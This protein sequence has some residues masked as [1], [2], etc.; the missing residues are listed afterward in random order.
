MKQQVIAVVGSSS[1]SAGEWCALVATSGAVPA[2]KELGTSAVIGA[3]AWVVAL[4]Q[5]QAPMTHG[6]WLRSLPAPIVLITP[7]TLAAQALAPLVPQLKVISPPARAL[8]ELADMLVL[9]LASAAGTL[10]VP[11]QGFESYGMRGATAWAH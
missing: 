3:D 6:F 7:H 4:D 1:Q 5:W 8:H 9:A 10:V 2:P 11:A